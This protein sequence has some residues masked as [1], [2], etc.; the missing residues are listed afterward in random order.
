MHTLI[1]NHDFRN[2]LLLIIKMRIIQNEWKHLPIKGQ[3]TPLEQVAKGI[4]GDKFWFLG[5]EDGNYFLQIYD[6]SQEETEERRFTP[7]D[8][9]LNGDN[10]FFAGMDMLNEETFLFRWAEYT[11]DEEVYTQTTDL[12]VFAHL[13]GNTQSVNVWELFKERKKLYFL[14]GRLFVEG[15][16]FSGGA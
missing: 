16:S 1:E 3:D 12:F 5:K 7:K 2:H 4:C 14:V 9:G 13:N 15:I 11:Q 10:G 6:T 8:L